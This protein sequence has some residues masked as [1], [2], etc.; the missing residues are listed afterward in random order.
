M[1]HRALSMQREIT[2]MRWQLI[3]IIIGAHSLMCGLW[4][5]PWARSPWQPLGVDLYHHLEKMLHTLKCHNDK[6]IHQITEK[7]LQLTISGTA[8]VFEN[9]LLT[10]PMCIN[11]MSILIRT[12]QHHRERERER[13]RDEEEEEIIMEY[14][15]HQI[16][17]HFSH[18]VRTQERGQPRP[19]DST[20]VDPKICIKIS[21]PLLQIVWSMNYCLY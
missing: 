7:T 20:R 17:K 18:L 9:E 11:C 8:V 21:Q 6:N 14:D 13:E 4:C 12:A 2:S 5:N 3:I 15:F 16:K 10:I 19:Y 1:Q